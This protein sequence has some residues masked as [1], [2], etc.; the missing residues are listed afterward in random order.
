MV[1]VV[2]V[3]RRKIQVNTKQENETEINKK[4]NKWLD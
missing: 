1:E 4:R 3:K 2:V